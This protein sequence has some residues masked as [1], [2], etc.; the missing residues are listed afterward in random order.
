M[1]PENGDVIISVTTFQAVAV[2]RC[3]IGYILEG[4]SNRTCWADRT[5]SGEKPL[6]KG[7]ELACM[8]MY[9]EFLNF[10]HLFL[11]LP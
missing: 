8:Y 4:S 2:Y 5:W 10:C 7:K 9:I 6:C 1:R 11:V 3:K